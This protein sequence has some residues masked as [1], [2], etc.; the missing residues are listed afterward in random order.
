MTHKQK[1]FLLGITGAAAV[2]AMLLLFTPLGNFLRGDVFGA[3]T[4]HQERGLYLGYITSSGSDL[5][6]KSGTGVVLEND[7]Y[8]RTGGKTFVD[9][10]TVTG[11][12]NL[13]A[14]TVSGVI[15]YD[16][17]K[18]SASTSSIVPEAGI[19]ADPFVT[20]VLTQNGSESGTLRFQF[21]YS[22]PFTKARQK[23]GH[24]EFTVLGQNVQTD[25][26]LAT[27]R[28]LAAPSLDVK[29][30]LF[31]DEQG[32]ENTLAVRPLTVKTDGTT[33]TKET[34]NTT[35]SGTVIKETIT[36]PDG[37]S[38]TKETWQTTDPNGGIITHILETYKDPNGNII[39]T[40]ETTI[41]P[42]GSKTVVE[43]TYPDGTRT[44]THY[45]PDGHVTEI[46]KTYPNGVV[47]HWWYDTQGREIRYE[48]H[49]A[50]D[51]QVYIRE[52]TYDQNGTTVKEWWYENGKL[53]KYQVTYPDGSTL[54]DTYTYNPD[55]SYTVHSVFTDKNGAQIIIDKVYD[56]D[57]NL[58]SAT[59]IK[60]EITLSDAVSLSAGNGEA[61]VVLPANASL[62]QV[63]AAL[64]AANASTTPAPT[65]QNFATGVYNFTLTNQN[66][67]TQVQDLF[68]PGQMTFTFNPATL[69]KPGKTISEIIPVMYDS[70]SNTWMSV[71]PSN[72]IS[73]NNTAATIH[74]TKAGKYAVLVRY[75]DTPPVTIPVSGGGSSGGSGGS[76]PPVAQVDYNGAGG[77]TKDPTVP[78]KTNEYCASPAAPFTD[79]RGHWGERYIEE[80]RMRCI[81]GGKRVGI[82][83]PNSPV[84]RAELT[85]I[86]VGAYK[87]QILTDLK[88][89]PFI[90]VSL[91]EWYATFIATA[92]AEKMVSGYKDNSFKPNVSIN[93][94]EALKIIVEGAKAQLSETIGNM[95]FSDVK[96]TD[97]FAG[98]VQ[99]GQKNNIISGYKE[100][101]T[102]L[103]KPGNN[104]TRAEAVK[105]II[106]TIK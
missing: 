102:V 95:I 75:T 88:D 91:R 29:G 73:K 41:Y 77:G 11:S 104:I 53:V 69:N 36:N 97:W 9:I 70:T 56:K 24:I 18:L 23:V 64:A 54:V 76:Y 28:M 62:K 58:I 61:Q 81:I 2:I 105:I 68:L 103:F 71:N 78:A 19:T 26:K 89:K 87:K 32:T 30:N 72:I 3:N 106:E 59:L 100:N 83:E 21:A 25:V 44:E 46:I 13:I 22:G 74:I 80:A 60:D 1:R 67:N 50:G 6:L 17:T 8:I 43:T 94:A 93:R 16:T 48:R 39:R 40:V 33:Y 4:T 92:K 45:A 66:N 84:T 37:S 20:E 38:Y 12:G 85:K 7:G 96:N 42:D 79:I 5:V 57:G 82:F 14:N 47:E 35:S 49:T 90:D 52:T 65:G 98:Y 34:I 27:L 63:V 15:A 10:Y 101:G 51:A 55:G 99:Y 31:L 86:V